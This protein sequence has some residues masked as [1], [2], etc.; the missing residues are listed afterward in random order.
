MKIILLVES[1]VLGEEVFIVEVEVLLEV[2][3]AEE[4][5]LSDMTQINLSDL[6][7]R[8]LLL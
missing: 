5:S 3:I 1:R 7:Y 4:V 6:S 8:R 2:I